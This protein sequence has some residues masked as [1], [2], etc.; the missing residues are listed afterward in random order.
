MGL[1]KITQRPR[2]LV[3]ARQV[4]VGFHLCPSSFRLSWKS[5]LCKRGS[6]EKEVC[7]AFSESVLKTESSKK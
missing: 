5:F 2:D 6:R 3:S 1:L 7:L 4:Q